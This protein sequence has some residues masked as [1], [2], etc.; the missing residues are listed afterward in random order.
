MNDPPVKFDPDQKLW[1]YTHRLKTLE[2]FKD[3]ESKDK[4]DRG[5]VAGVRGFPTAAT[6][7]PGTPWKNA[8]GSNFPPGGFREEGN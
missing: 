6:M 3:L 7:T 2:H 4:A 1:I 8:S 5:A